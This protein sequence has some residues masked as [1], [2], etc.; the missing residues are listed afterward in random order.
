M[1]H[2]VGCYYRRFGTIYRFHRQGAALKMQW[3]FSL[4]EHGA[5]KL[6]R[7]VGKKSAAET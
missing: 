1:L 6:S 7:N 2:M 4:L 5:D 3:K